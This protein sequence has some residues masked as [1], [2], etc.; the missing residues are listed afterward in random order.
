M[1]EPADTDQDWVPHPEPA[2]STLLARGVEDLLKAPIRAARR[3][4]G[5][6]THPEAAARQ[7]G[8]ALEG[9]G[10]IGWAFVQPRDPADPPAL[11]ELREFVGRE[12]ASFKRPDGLTVLTE[13][14]VTPMFKVDK[15]ALRDLH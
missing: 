13:L 11:A 6:V 15:R 1:P 9:V 10:E 8:Q 5:A 14:P 7:A 4:Q 12:L 2:S 3:V